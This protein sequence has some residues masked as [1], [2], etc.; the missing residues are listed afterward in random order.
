MMPGAHEVGE[1]HV[2]VS[3][4]LIFCKLHNI[5]DTHQIS[6][7]YSGDFCFPDFFGGDSRH[8]ITQRTMDGLRTD[9]KAR[10]ATGHD[11]KTD[12]VAVL[13]WLFGILLILA[14]CNYVPASGDID[15]C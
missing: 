7:S 9:A 6:P 2:D 15:H 3:N 14:K 5:F 8:H 4:L 1:T 12:K 10:S 11:L 13:L